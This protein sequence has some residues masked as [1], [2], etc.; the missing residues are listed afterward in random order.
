VSSAYR[1]D[2]SAATEQR[3]AAILFQAQAAMQG[4]E[5]VDRLYVRI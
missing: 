2:D 5:Q 1:H 4:R 3:I